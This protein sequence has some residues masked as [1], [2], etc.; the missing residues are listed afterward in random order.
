M[1]QERCGSR[2]PRF[3]TPNSARRGKLSLVTT[4]HCNR[5]LFNGRE[6]GVVALVALEMPLL[7]MIMLNG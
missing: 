2:C 3:V 6:H 5:H 7:D 1:C 4:S